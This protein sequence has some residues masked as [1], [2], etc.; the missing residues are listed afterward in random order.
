M[1][2]KNAPVLQ[3]K[4]IINR[5]KFGEKNLLIGKGWHKIIFTDVKSSIFMV[6]VDGNAIDT[7]GP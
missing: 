3:Q 4:H 5:Q 2:R 7:T 6:Q 1:T